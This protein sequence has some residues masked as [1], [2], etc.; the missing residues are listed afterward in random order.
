MRILITNDD[1]IEAA[2]I[3]LLERVARSLSRDVWVVA[4]ESEQSGASHSLTLTEPLRIR[5]LTPRKFAVRGTPTDSV[6]MAVN[7]LVGGKRPDL[8]LSGVNRGG[9]L[10]EDVTYSGT[11]AAAM[12]GTLLK[13]PSIAFSQV[14]RFGHPVK[15]ATA[16]HHAPKIIRRLL[17]LGWPAGVLINVNFPDV[18]HDAVAGVAVTPQGQ[19]DLT[20]LV[21]D[22]RV[23]TRGVAYHWIGFR[24]QVGTPMPETDL[25]AVA[26]GQISITPLQLDLTHRPAMENL[27]KGLA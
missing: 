13:L 1:G 21:I 18:N 9:N 6:M 27:R 24:R 20:D 19:R 22:S 25:A 23:D 10:G 16:E 7:Q 4:P 12:E 15:W 17:D 14:M 8:L 5:K 11:I 3:K 2:G 26:N